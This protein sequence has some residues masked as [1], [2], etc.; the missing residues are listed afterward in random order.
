MK[1][2]A[3][4]PTNK[5][6]LDKYYAVRYKGKINM[7]LNR[8]LALRQGVSVDDLK[9]LK[10]THRERLRLFDAIELETEPLE[11]QALAK[12]IANIEFKLQDGWNFPRDKNFH[13][14][15][16]KLPKCEC[17]KMDNDDYLGTELGVITECCPLHGK[18]PA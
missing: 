12:K 15:W 14:W 6:K 17:P 7:Y 3:P 18:V 4:I 11:L 16:Y 2:K 5:K 10:N 13:S 8:S 1:E 9:S